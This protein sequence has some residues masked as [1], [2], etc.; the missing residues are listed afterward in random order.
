MTDIDGMTT[1]EQ[2]ALSKRYGKNVAIVIPLRDGSFAVFSEDLTSESLLIVD[3]NDNLA[4]AINSRAN[5]HGRKTP[6]KNRDVGLNI[7]SLL[8]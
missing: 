7:K 2:E 8:E 3:D 5:M 1:Q 4:I 6:S